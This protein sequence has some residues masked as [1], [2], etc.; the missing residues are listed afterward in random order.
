MNKI[1][2][3]LLLGLLSFSSEIFPQNFTDGYNFNLPA[4]DTTH[5]EFLPEFPIVSIEDNNFVSTD[6]EGN[7]IV[8]QNK[9]R[10]WG[11]NLVGEGCFPDKPI[12]WYIAGRLRNMGF[13]IVR[14]HHMDNPWGNGSLFVPG[15]DTRHLNSNSLDKL[16]YLL[17]QL[18]QNGIYANINLH[19]SRTF[20]SLDGVENADSITEFG[21]AVTIFDPQLIS[22]QKEFATQLLTHVNP[23][24]GLALK[25]DPVM[26]LLEITNE[27]SLYRWWRDN[28]LKSFSQGG[29]LIIRHVRMLDSLWIRYLINK[30]TTTVNLKSAWG[31]GTNI[32]NQINYVKNGDFETPPI[33]QH[34][35]LELHD[36][37]NAAIS[38]D[39]I[40][41]IQGNYSGKIS[42]TK[43]TG[44]EWHLQFKQIGLTAFLDSIY[45]VQF[46]AKSDGNN[47]LTVI[48]MRDNDPYNVYSVHSFALTSDWNTFDFSF[49]SSEDNVGQMRL[50]FEFAQKGNYWLDNIFLTNASIVGLEDGETLESRS[51]K[52][53]DYFDSYSYSDQRIKDIS[54][55]YINLQN[56]YFENMTKFLKDTIGVKC[57]IVGTNWNIGP[58]DLITQSNSDFIDNHSYWDHPSFLGTPWSSTD[59][60]I[61]NTPMVQSQSGGTIPD[62]FSGVPFLNK[63]FTISEYNHAFPNQFQTEGVLFLTVYSSFHDADA[64]MFF[65]Y[66]GSTDWTSDFVSDY[67]AIH[68]NGSMMGLMPSCAFAFR[69]NLISKAKE[70]LTLKYNL[71]DIYLLPKHDTGNWNG[72]TLFSKK[73]ALQHAIRNENFTSSE[74][75]VFAQLPSD[76]V[77]PY[78]TDTGEII[79]DTNGLLSIHS[80]N[81]IGIS[82]LL[83]NF[84]QTEVG[85]LKLNSASGFG[86][87]TWVALNNDS[88]S[89]SD[90]SLIT[91]STTLQNTNMIWDGTTTIHNNWGQAPT[92][93]HPITATLE[94]NIFADSIKIY[95]LTSE[96]NPII[97]LPKTYLPSLS[98]R[99]MIILNQSAEKTIW[100]GIQKFGTGSVSASDREFVSPIEFSIQQNYPNPFNGQTII[101][102]S[103]GNPTNV[104]ISIYDVLGRKVRTL[105][106]KEQSSG[107]YSTNWDSKNDVGV[108]VVSG[109]YFIR[110]TTKIYSSVIK[111]MLIK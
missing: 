19:V 21:K 1:I 88:L 84:S 29:S 11:T 99:F 106:N 40:N 75:S 65:D 3:L 54:E 53:I 73:L 72:P 109:I 22:L 4:D 17:N 30:Y 104:E 13:N 33:T 100:Y 50:S 103:I 25:D 48:T 10:F 37:A 101:N 64:I 41:P 44:T 63:P 93:L 60:N 8:A 38:L 78:K 57:P 94:L 55:F 82:G 77:N 42:V 28:R 110:F 39:N 18:K 111:T 81:F 51:V 85:N 27:N 26:A 46:S 98:N 6:S 52:R 79:Y 2:P 45:T 68:R 9:I 97:N 5:S 14:F 80:P 61:S 95:P 59:W 12:A 67:F 86:T 31:L 16:E 36:T 56:K 70:I 107:Y 49:I 76:P 62:L 87:I 91:L 96:G 105:L 108:S 83:D 43:I 32:N 20:N 89:V 15:S 23:Y 102:Y 74:T 35:Q 34:W 90:K 47:T 92:Q 71:E 66:N 7:F 69:H 24:T 58:G